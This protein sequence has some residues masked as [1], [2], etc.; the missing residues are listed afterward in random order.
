MC[1]E[2]TVQ[3]RTSKGAASVHEFVQL[4]LPCAVRYDGVNAAE[5]QLDATIHASMKLFSQVKEGESP[6]AFFCYGASVFRG[7][8]A[9]PQNMRLY[10]AHETNSYLSQDRRVDVLLSFVK[11]GK[12]ISDA[13][14]SKIRDLS[15]L[16]DVTRLM[17]ELNSY[18]LNKKSAIYRAVEAACSALLENKCVVITSLYEFP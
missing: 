1:S 17:L 12:E 4:C 10:R 3:F 5:E 16:Q 6:P 7:L 8:P 13:Q 18:G 14:G 9:F 15:N 11:L 2:A